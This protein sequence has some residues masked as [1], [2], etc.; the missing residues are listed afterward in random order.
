MDTGNTGLVL[1]PIDPPT[2]GFA[3][4]AIRDSFDCTGLNLCY[5]HPKIFHVPSLSS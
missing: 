4:I 2:K 3:L 1:I 5:Y